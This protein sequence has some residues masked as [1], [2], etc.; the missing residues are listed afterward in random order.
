VL[1]DI[2]RPLIA[3][4]AIGLG[5]AVLLSRA[6]SAWLFNITPHDPA[7]LLAATAL[8]FLIASVAAWLPARDALHTDPNA[9][10]R[11]E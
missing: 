7:M 6:L 3:G 10:L 11:S 9:V 5:I 1:I 2:A 4:A 8:L